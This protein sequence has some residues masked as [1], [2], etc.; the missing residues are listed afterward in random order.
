MQRKTTWFRIARLVFYLAA[1]LFFALL[2]YAA[3]EGGWMVCPSA[4]MGFPCPGCGA[5][6][7]LSLLMKG[8]WIEAWDLNRVF[9]GILFP[10]G[11]LTMLQ[12]VFV[13][14]TRKRL[15]FLEYLMGWNGG[16]L[17]GT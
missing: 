13:T 12:D 9:C 1:V 2:P 5:T 4:A 3:V 14:V 10:A 7:A 11:A 8:R 15:S 17:G 6:R 16:T